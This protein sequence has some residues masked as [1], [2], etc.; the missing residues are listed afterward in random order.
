MSRHQRLLARL[1]D[2]YHTAA[3][4]GKGG[5]VNIKGTLRS[6]AFGITP[7]FTGAVGIDAGRAVGAASLLTST[8]AMRKTVGVLIAD[9]GEAFVVAI[10]V[11]A[12]ALK[13]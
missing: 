10:A 1:A 4:R 11:V 12:D 8:G 2:H 6:L 9:A 5:A 7:G 3:M 13:R